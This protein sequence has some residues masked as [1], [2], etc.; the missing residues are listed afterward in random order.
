M[1]R[2]YNNPQ[3]K[4]NCKIVNFAVPVDHWVKL[5]ENEKKN[6]YLYLARERKKLWNMK[7]TI[8]SI[9]IGALG[10]V[11]KRFIKELE[12]LEKKDE[13]RPSK[14]LLYWDQQEYWEESWR[15]EETY[16]R[17]NFSKRPSTNADM[18]K[19]SRSKIIIIIII[20]I[21]INTKFLFTILHSLILPWQLLLPLRLLPTVSSSSAPHPYLS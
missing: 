11:T 18:E 7:V 5:K 17:S 15:L 9:I 21:I 6:R 2:F 13:W 3:K 8:I 14:L 12:D 20:I 10:T 16:N 19:L 1:I 4:R